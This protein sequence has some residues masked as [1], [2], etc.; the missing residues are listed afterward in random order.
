MGTSIFTLGHQQTQNSEFRY[1]E[2]GDWSGG[3]LRLGSDT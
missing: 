2:G 1:A 3:V